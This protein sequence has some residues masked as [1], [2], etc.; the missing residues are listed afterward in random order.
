MPQFR[1]RMGQ[2]PDPGPDPKTAAGPLRA[3]FAERY[4]KINKGITKQQRLG[5]A[6]AGRPGKG[7]SFMRKLY[8]S[9]T[10]N[11][12]TGL[13]GGIAAWLGVNST[14]VRL[15]AVIAAL[16]SFGTVLLIYIL[17]SLVVP[18]EPYMHHHF[19]PFFDHR[20]R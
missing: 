14:F 4:N 16:F 19:D 10:D 15:V 3:S 20:Y 7:E 17:C 1:P 13:C 11:K 9:R 8:R 6:G 2:I 18:S 12:L 5:A